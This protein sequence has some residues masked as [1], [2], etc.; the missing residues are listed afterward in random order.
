MDQTPKPEPKWRGA[1][2]AKLA[3]P[4]PDQ[5][6]SYLKDFC[7]LDR[8]IPTLHTCR[9]VEGSDG[10]VGCVRYC[11][12]SL[13]RSDPAAPVGWSKERLVDFDPVRR[14]YSYEVVESNKGF[15]SYAATI[16]VGSDPDGGCCV[17]WSFESDPVK[18][19]TYE[20]FTSYLESLARGVA[21]RLEA[22][23]NKSNKH[24]K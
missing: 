2:R 17:E 19:W 11:A 8:W 22:E 7:A 10:E 15:G 14:S 21:A 20:G 18:G 12:G 1:V 24:D 16:R 23:I 4:T 3:G 13:N 6:W 9:K 5:A